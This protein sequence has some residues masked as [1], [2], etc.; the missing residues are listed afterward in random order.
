MG[1]FDV[2]HLAQEHWYRNTFTS[3]LVALAVSLTCSSISFG[4]LINNRGFMIMVCASLAELFIQY[5]IIAIAFKSLFFKGLFW[6]PD[7]GPEAWQEYRFPR[8]AR[9]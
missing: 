2:F 8:K 1:P 7:P 4:L 3:V 6:A 5:K 9:Q